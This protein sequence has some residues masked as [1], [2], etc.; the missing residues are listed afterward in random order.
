MQVK[1][2]TAQFQIHPSSSPYTNYCRKTKNI[3]G[4]SFKL[5]A[6]ILLF[7]SRFTEEALPMIHTEGNYN[8]VKKPY[9]VCCGPHQT[10]LWQ[11]HQAV[12]DSELA[13][14]SLDLQAETHIQTLVHMQ[15]KH[16]NYSSLIN[17]LV[18]NWACAFYR[19]QELIIL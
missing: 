18:T 9:L 6:L 7:P 11:I 10:L 2:E 5:I 3:I 14:L 15:I 13:L 8:E 17:T 16:M 1:T 19:Q 4:V 12:Q